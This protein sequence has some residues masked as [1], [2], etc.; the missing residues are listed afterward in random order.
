MKPVR[1]TALWACFTVSGAAALAL[2]MLWMRSAGLVLGQT[3][4]TTA[5]VLACYFGGLALGAACA[6]SGARRPVRAYGA[7]ELGAAAGAL[8]SVVAFRALASDVAQGW[9]A[10]AGPIGGAAA[11]ALAV[12]PA[13]VCLGATLPAIGQA[14]VSIEELGHRGGLLYA[15]NTLGGVVGLAAMGF[16]MPAV[17]GVT[18]SYGAAAAASALAGA[19]ALTVS[20]GL[21][22][23]LPSARL[24]F[25]ERRGGT[26]PPTRAR[27]RLVAAG[28]GA[29]GLA[30]EVLWTRLFAQ[31][32][33]NS[34]Y[35]FSAVA[36]VFLIALAIG[37]AVS[38][39]LL[40]RARPAA[41][42]GV[43]L[44]VA[45]AGTAAGAWT[46]VRCTD[47][48]AYFGMNS[49]LG[50]YLLR[51]VGLAALTVGPAA[52]ASGAV[53]P[54]LWALWGGHDSAARPLGDLS[55]LNMVGGIGGAL[56]AGYLALPLLGL[57]GGLLGVAM[58]YVVLA[59]IVAPLPV[60]LRP[61]AYGVVLG[62]AFFID[63]TRIP[64][65]HLDP[66]T[67]TLR[68]ARE[69]PSGFVTVVESGAD[70]QLR[71]DNYYVLG[72]TAS[73]TTERRLGLVPLLLHPRPERVAF[74]GLATGITASAAPALG[75]D[76]TTVV[77]V[78]PEVA[79]VA[80]T[81]FKTWNDGLLDRPDVHLVLG[82][83]RRYLAATGERFDVIVSDLFIPWHA[84]AGSLYSR[85]MYETVARR[86]APGGLFCQWLPLY[87][88]TREEFDII[89]HTFLSVFPHAG[90][91]RADF[92]PDRPVAALI[93][94]QGSALDLE[95]IRI[96]VEGL[97]AWSRDP[98]LASPRGLVMLYAGNLAAAPDLFAAAPINTDDRPLIEFT[99]PRLTRMSAAGDKDWLTGESLAAVYDRLAD[100]AWHESDPLLP[101][102]GEVANARS[103]G[104]AL[105]RY[106]IAATQGNNMSARELEA[107]VRALVPEVIAAFE[108]TDT[109]DQLR[110]ALR[111]K[112]RLRAEAERVR[113]RLDVM[114]HRLGELASSRRETP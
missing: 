72:G 33:H 105:Y 75:V 18:A 10:A 51:I 111:E 62:I 66:A 80:R 49:G 76:A 3:A 103:A 7:L 55:A 28:A 85:E 78:V 4:R 59:D 26:P 93:A 112:A 2:E 65:S 88:L 77:E 107:T 82:D 57:H 1:H 38:A 14:L 27:L 109:T 106:A 68:A 79:D 45:A 20:R 47:G 43:A 102:A 71:L 37:S 31:V 41:V 70:L 24:D 86:L 96:R 30:L 89:A 87:Q 22:A 35:S 90:L 11:I 52:L 46:F 110:E 63:P 98:L 23:G 95:A 44:A 32:L 60:R 84:G 21:G 61:L 53:L 36:L 6:R 34:T 25:G 12:L 114:Q 17:I 13:T 19:V 73:E 56:A 97:P 58:A 16:G 104:R 29:L 69:G 54:A 100:R 74:I 48:L 83:G 39:V 64:V 8:W 15:A 108:S 67:D 99:A 42:A 92:F 9:L 101:A 113:H 81:D 94:Q 50:E 40:G 91:W 5:T